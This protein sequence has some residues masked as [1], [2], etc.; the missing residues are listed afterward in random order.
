MI[1]FI[2]S[3]SF[4]DY[5]NYAKRERL[6]TSVS[7]QGISSRVPVIFKNK[8]VMS[9]TFKVINNTTKFSSFFYF[10]GLLNAFTMHD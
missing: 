1:I 3:P 6:Q 5:L 2:T 8:T 10:Y 9:E 7:M 4:L